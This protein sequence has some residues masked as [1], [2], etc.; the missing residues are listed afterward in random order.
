MAGMTTDSSGVRPPVVET[1]GDEFLEPQR[2][3]WVTWPRSNC[4]AEIFKHGH[5]SMFSKYLAAAP[6]H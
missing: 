4:A 2:M 1:Q 3:I 6:S 5:T